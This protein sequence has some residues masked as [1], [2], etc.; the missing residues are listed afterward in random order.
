MDGPEDDPRTADTEVR[1]KLTIPREALRAGSEH[2]IRVASTTT[3]G[4]PACLEHE[5]LRSS[6]TEAG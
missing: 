3:H 5:G 4:L 6:L 2:G 1:I